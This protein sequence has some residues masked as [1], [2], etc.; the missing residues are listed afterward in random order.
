MAKTVKKENLPLYLFHQGTNYKTYEY[1]GAHPHKQ[2]RSTGAIFRTWAP[3]ARAVSVT[4]DFNDWKPEANPMQRISDNGVWEVFVPGV[5]VYDNY[6]YCITAAD[7]REIYKADPYAFHAETRPGT[8]SKFVDISGYS[9]GDDAWYAK[10]QGLNIYHSPMNIYEVHL[11]SW[12]TYEDGA[13]FDY[14]KMAEELIPYAKDMGYTHLEIMPITEYPFDGSWGYQVTGYFAPTSR[15]GTPQDL[16]YFIDQ[17]HQAD[18]GVIM[19]WVPG[20]FPKDAYG[21]YEYDG[22]YCYEYSDPQKREHEQWGTRIFDYGR[23][24]VLSFLISSAMFWVEQYHMDGIRVDAVASML[25]LDYGREQWQWTPNVNGGKENLEAVA[26]LQKLNTAV[27]TEHPSAL[28]IAEESTSW[29]LVTKPPMVGGLGFNFKWNMGWMNDMLAYTSLDPIYRAYNHDKLTF[30]MFYAFSENF[31]LPIS[32]DEV[33]Y[34]KC[35]LINKMPGEYDQK[36]AGMRAFLG[37]MM[38]HPGKKLLFM[39]Q[40]FAQF[41]EWNYQTELDWNLFDFEKHRKMHDF[42]RTINHFYLDNPC[43]WQVEDSWDG[44]QWISHDDHA[45][46]IVSFRRIDEKGNEVVV[47]CNFCPVGRTAYRIGVPDA[48]KYQ[49]VLNTDDVAF[50]GEG[51]LNE[52][53]PVEDIEMHGFEQSIEFQVPPLSCLF[54]KAVPGRRKHTKKKGKAAVKPAKKN[55]ETAEEKPEKKAPAKRDRPAKPKTE[56]AAAAK[57]VKAEAVL[58]AEAPK[59]AA[60]PR[61]APVR[62]KAAPETAAAETAPKTAEKPARKPRKKAAPKVEPEGTEAAGKSGKPDSKPDSEAK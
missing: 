38:A 61:K 25:Y 36:F 44:F 35:S 7:G 40:E 34:G 26:F 45:Q 13:Q 11:G 10:K 1:L 48:A 37:Y 42:V 50:G 2:G 53:V 29:P 49:E 15:Y 20:H 58:E 56:D 5:K 16:M 55:A 6:K 14:R 23:N 28:M 46:N 59:P 31:I 43:M 4:G 27:L 41:N 22:G 19:D 9:W 17:C 32:H 21:L 18:L 30:S 39:G 3:N 54:F 60:K 8:A 47:L 12:R 24:E 51:R 52:P 62:K 57:A 33:V